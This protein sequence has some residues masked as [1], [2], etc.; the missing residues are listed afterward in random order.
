MCIYTFL[1]N[2][3]LPPPR[4]LINTHPILGTNVLCLGGG[5]HVLFMLDVD[6]GRPIIGRHR[7]TLVSNVERLKGAKRASLKVV[8]R[9]LGNRK[10]V[11]ARDGTTM[12]A[13][14]DGPRRRR[15]GRA[16]GT[17][18]LMQQSDGPTWAGGAG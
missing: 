11:T 1:I 15:R 16:G 9:E 4:Y 17:E 10:T 12:S 13:E 2:G 14:G 6:G 5:R 8:G 3:K 18:P 7:V